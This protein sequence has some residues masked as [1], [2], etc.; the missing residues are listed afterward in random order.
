MLQS[1]PQRTRPQRSRPQRRGIWR[2]EQL[3]RAA[4]ELIIRVPLSEVTYA[5][6]CARAEIPPSSAYHFYPDLDAICRALL[7]TDQAGM[8]GALMRSLTAAQSRTWQ[9]VV[10]CLVE[11]AARYNRTHPVAAKLAIGGQTP[12]QLKRVDREADRVRSGLALRALDELFV[13]PRVPHM[14]RVAFLAIEIVDT[15]FTASMI[16]RGRLTTGYVKLA[17][18][19]A[20]GFLTQFFGER[21][22]R[23]PAPRAA[24]ARS[25]KASG[26]RAGRRPSI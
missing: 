2:R 8:D 23:R 26:R 14:K 7:V 5:A 1:F 19:A 6:I 24:A 9:S 15:V 22:P 10:G 11:R 20:I 16:E 21:M 18:A 3:L 12:P 17:K 4:G 25:T 13:L